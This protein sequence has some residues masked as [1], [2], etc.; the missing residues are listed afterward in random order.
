MEEDKENEGGKKKVRNREKGKRE[1]GLDTNLQVLISSIIGF[2]IEFVPYF[3]E[4]FTFC[5]RIPVQLQININSITNK[6]MI[7]AIILLDPIGLHT[8]KS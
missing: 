8:S 2:K 3:F 1:W 5:N 6:I 7:S 4:V